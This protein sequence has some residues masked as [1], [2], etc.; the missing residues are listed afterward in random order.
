M[1]DY[2]LAKQLKDAGFPQEAAFFH[3]ESE[4]PDNRRY[5]RPASL[6]GLGVKGTPTTDQGL[7]ADPTLEELIEA[8]GEKFVALYRFKRKL[9]SGD[10]WKTGDLRINDHEVSWPYPESGEGPTPRQAVAKLWLALNK[11]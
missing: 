5:H 4:Y 6:Y 7:I 9:P 11:K 1:L 10:I 3:E 8:C 2:E